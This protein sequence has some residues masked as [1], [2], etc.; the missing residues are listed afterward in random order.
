[1]RKEDIFRSSWTSRLIDVGEI[2]ASVAIFLSERLGFRNIMDLT[3]FTKSLVRLDRGRPLLGSS[4][5][6][7]FEVNLG[8][9][10]LIF[11]E[12]LAALKLTRR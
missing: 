2:P 10:I 6:L 4:S 12:L 9:D 3:L 8:S 7:P 11:G 5:T 1:M